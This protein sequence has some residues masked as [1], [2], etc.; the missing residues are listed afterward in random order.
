MQIIHIL[1]SFFYTIF[2]EL[3]G[4]SMEDLIGALKGYYCYGPYKPKVSIQDKIV[5]VELDKE[6]IKAQEANL[7]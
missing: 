5:Y 6:I 2:P 7:H 3:Q 1:D 4:K